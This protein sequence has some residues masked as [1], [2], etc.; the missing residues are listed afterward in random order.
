[1]HRVYIGYRKL[2]FS[3]FI[4]PWG[5][6]QYHNNTRLFLSREELYKVIFSLYEVAHLANCA[7]APIPAPNLLHAAVASE[8]LSILN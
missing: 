6:T 5:K 8:R 7:D 2:S 1:M 3:L 4:N